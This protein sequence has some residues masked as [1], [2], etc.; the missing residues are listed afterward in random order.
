MSNYLGAR[1]RVAFVDADVIFR[2]GLR[3]ML[4]ARNDFEWVGEASSLSDFR[5]RFSG[6]GVQVIM[7]DASLLT[8]LDQVYVNFWMSAWPH[9]KFLLLVPNFK[10][11]MV[12]LYLKW[13][14]HGVVNKL[15]MQEEVVAAF[16]QVFFQ[17]AYVHPNTKRMLDAERKTIRTLERITAREIDVIRGICQ[18]KTCKEIAHDLQISPR[19]VE[20]H[21]MRIIEKLDVRNTAGIIVHAVRLGIIP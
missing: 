13:G 3:A 21:K 15:N 11:A 16:R 8:E 7:I 19:T 2:S 6:V 10:S 20:T 18:E 12:P 1:I 17:Q 14:F 4:E 5:A 9:A